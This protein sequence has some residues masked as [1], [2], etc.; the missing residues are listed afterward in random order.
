MLM[1]LFSEAVDDNDGSPPS[2]SDSQFVDN[3]R[4]IHQANDKTKHPAQ[5]F[6]GG[7]TSQDD[8]ARQ[9]A[10]SL[11]PAQIVAGLPALTQPTSNISRQEFAQHV[12]PAV[13]PP[14]S[15]GTWDLWHSI[16]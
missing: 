10:M 6:Q 15:V 9:S 13:N 8:L 3:M 1:H 4:A 11:Q 5:Q 12:L 16:R 7:L 2:L 14:P